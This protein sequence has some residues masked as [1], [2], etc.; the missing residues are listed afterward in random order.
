MGNNRTQLMIGRGFTAPPG[1]G[2]DHAVW[3]SGSSIYAQT[4]S[5]CT[6]IVCGIIMSFGIDDHDDARVKYTI[7]RSSVSLIGH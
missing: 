4:S 3:P 2:A 6:Q 1:A 5:H 7:A